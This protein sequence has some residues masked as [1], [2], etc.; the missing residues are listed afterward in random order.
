MDDR[1]GR[2]C[3]ALPDAIRLVRMSTTEILKA[4]PR[5]SLKERRKILRRLQEL[6]TGCDVRRP[7]RTGRAPKLD[8]ALLTQNP[9]LA[10]LREE[11]DLYG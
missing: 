9:S 8:Y 1:K 4:L 10:F 11:P 6:E 7:A 5:L 2:T 3:V